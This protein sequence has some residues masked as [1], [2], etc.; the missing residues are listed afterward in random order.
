MSN[1]SVIAYWIEEDNFEFCS[2][3]MG[4]N[5]IFRGGTYESEIIEK[6]ARKPLN[7]YVLVVP[8]SQSRN[9]WARHQVQQLRD[10]S[11][12]LRKLGG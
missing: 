7:D 1:G 6:F 9:D 2:K 10:K 12:A 3:L 4:S 8:L 11:T 5:H